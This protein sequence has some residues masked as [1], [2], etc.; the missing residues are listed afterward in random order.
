L[1]SSRSA[2]MLGA[3]V[4]VAVAI[5]VMAGLYVGFQMG[6]NSAAL[7]SVTAPIPS[8]AKALI[9]ASPASLLP[10]PGDFPGLYA[11]TGLQAD[12]IVRVPAEFETLQGTNGNRLSATLSVE[13]YPTIGL[14]HDRFQHIVA[15]LGNSSPPAPRQYGDE[16]Q[17]TWAPNQSP[18]DL[19]LHWRDRNAVMDVTIYDN[20]GTVSV[21]DMQAA[22]YV[23]ADRFSQRVA[24]A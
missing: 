24:E 10:E 4:A 12:T 16:S 17:L 3:G 19:L 11:A 14:A 20:S 21:T 23:I 6:R 18:P 15:F 9:T 2:R 5:L 22:L 1:G 13:I 7:S 8:P